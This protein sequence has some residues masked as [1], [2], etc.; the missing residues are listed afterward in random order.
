[1]KE[2]IVVTGEAAGTAEND[3]GRAAGGGG[4]R[5]RL[6]RPHDGLHRHADVRPGQ[7]PLAGCVARRHRPPAL[8]APNSQRLLTEWI[9]TTR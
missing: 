5:L 2:A 7:R 8:P 1:M 4:E 3:A 9:T 6:R